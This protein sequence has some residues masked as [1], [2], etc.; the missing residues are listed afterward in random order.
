[1]SELFANVIAAFVTVPLLGFIVIY[2]VSKKIFKSSRRAVHLAIDWSTILL[3]LS[4]NQIIFVLWQKSFLWAIFLVLILVA[5]VFVF[6]HWKTKHEIVFRPIFK[7]FWRMNFLLFF[8]AHIF[9]LI[10]GL[11]QRVSN[12]LSP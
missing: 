5:L 4:V 11:F 12:L 10:L 1:M 8:T 6:I 3:I 2:F 9:L 7:G